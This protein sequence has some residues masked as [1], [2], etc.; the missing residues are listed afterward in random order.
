MTPMTTARADTLTKYTA[1]PTATDAGVT[2]VAMPHGANTLAITLRNTTNLMPAAHSSRARYR[3]EYSSSIASWI[4]V[5]SRCVAGLSTGTRPVSARATT[6]NA[7]RA[8]KCGGG[9]VMMPSI[10]AVLWTMVLRLVEPAVSAMAKMDSIMAGSA[11]VATMASRLL[12]IPPKA[13]PASKP[14]R[15]KKNVPRAKRYTKAMTLPAKFNGF[16]ETKIGTKSPA[17]SVEAKTM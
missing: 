9:A 11:S 15:I 17:A 4:I 13:D 16:W 10:S 6:K 3:P 12:P 2:L 1:M 14:A 7:T 8:I 5:S